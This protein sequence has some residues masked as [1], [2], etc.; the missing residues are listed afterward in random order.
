[1]RE[2]EAAH[3]AEKRLERQLSRQSTTTTA[4]SGRSEAGGGLGTG[5]KGDVSSS[6]ESMGSQHRV[7]GYEK[8]LDKDGNL[9]KGKHQGKEQ[10]LDKSYDH[11]SDNNK[12][13]DKGY[14][15]DYDMAP[16]SS[17]SSQ[18]IGFRRSYDQAS[19]SSPMNA[20]MAQSV[21]STTSMRAS[22]L[23][24]S[25]LVYIHSI[26]PHPPPSLKNSGV[27]NTTHTQTQRTHL[28]HSL[29]S[30]FSLPDLY[31]S[32]LR[33]ETYRSPSAPSSPGR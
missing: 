23:Q 12:G 20:S 33:Q 19:N 21:A 24:Q 11:G 7:K 16:S 27:I 17:T 22:T 2:R 10:E 4:P 5:W 14:E 30:L 9:G 18:G 8:G 15:K 26:H 1:M 3:K 28:A 32:T 25:S 6:Q 31:P 13:Y 29:S